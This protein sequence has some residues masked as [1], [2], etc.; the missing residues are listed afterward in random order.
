MKDKPIILAVD[1]QL[2]NIELLEAYLVG[3]GYKIIKA[4]RIA[5]N[6]DLDKV[7][8]YKTSAYLFDSFSKS[9]PGGTGKK[10]NWKILAQAVKMK[11]IVFVSGLSIKTL[12]NLAAHALRAVSASATASELADAADFYLAASFG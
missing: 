3:Q 2:Q 1:D 8:Q 6:E 7:S 11:P 10:F 9:K 5:K 12:K 4:F